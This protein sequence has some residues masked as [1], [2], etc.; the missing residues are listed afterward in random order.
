MKIVVLDGYTAIL[1]DVTMDEWDTLGEIAIYDRTE[2]QYI[3]ERAREAEVVLTNKTVL[4]RDIINALPDLRY[5]GVLATGYN[6]V[7]LAAASERGIVVTNIPAY[8]TMS[9]AQ[10][11]MAHL[12]NVTNHTADYAHAVRQGEWQRSDDFCF[13]LSPLTELDGQTMGI[14]GVG[15]IGR[16]VARMAQAMGMRV[17]A[18]SSK[19]AEE[20]ATLGIEKAESIEAL[21]R[22]AD[23]LSLHCPL[24]D[25]THELINTQTISWMKPNAILINTGRGPLINEQQLADALNEGRIAA[26]CLDVLCEEPPR[27]GSPL[28]EARNC[29]IT[30]HIAWASLAARQ[31]LLR[32]ARENVQAFAEGHPQ[33]QVN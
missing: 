12:L 20:L 14:V 32:I 21:F 10:T 23:V 13:V 26:A 5:I 3:I 8:S 22:Q 27:K 1:G 18:Y 19:Q 30:P 31:R 2:P 16:A 29:Y 11:V 9:V 24:N 28:I 6:V 33:N 7:D 17:V 4:T 25:Q 15:N